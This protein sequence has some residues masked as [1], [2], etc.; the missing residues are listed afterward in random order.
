[1]PEIVQRGDRVPEL[2]GIRGLAIL[3]VIYWHYVAIP[4]GGS[5]G[6]ALWLAR[7]G[8]YAW[9]GVD[10]FFALPGFLIGGIR[11]TSGTPRTTSGRSTRAARSGSPLNSST[12]TT[13]L[14]VCPNRRSSGLNSSVQKRKGGR[15]CRPPPDVLVLD[16]NL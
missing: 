12:T 9:S 3:L 15:H 8:L 10:L 1:L 11:S 7:A 13:G 5:G 6:P 2:D 14:S 4:F 16:Q